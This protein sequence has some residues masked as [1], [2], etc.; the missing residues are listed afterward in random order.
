MLT[1]VTHGSGVGRTLCAIGNGHAVDNGFRAVAVE[2]YADIV[3][4]VTSAE[5]RHTESEGAV[6]RKP[7][8]ERIAAG[9]ERR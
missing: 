5:C 9:G 1:V 4:S 3:G 2:I 7:A 6:G 8:S